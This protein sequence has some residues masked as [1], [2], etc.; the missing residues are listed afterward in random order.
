M[1]DTYTHGHHESVLR[2]HQWRTAENSAAYLLPSLRPGLDLL[3]VG[4]GPGT[5]TVD[6]AAR[7]APGNVVGVD[8]SADV[9]AQATALRHQ[10]GAANVTFSVVD[11][12]ALPF[13]DASFDV[14]H[15]H[16]VLQHVS[17]PVGM[18]REMHRVLRPGGLV[19]VR[20]SD[21]AAFMWA[22]A[23][24]M[25]DRWMQLYR[26][27][28]H[29]NGAQ[30][31]AGRHLLGWAHSAG[32]AD[33]VASSSTWT[34]ADLESR[35]WWGGLWADRMLLSSIAEQALAYGLSDSAELSAI[36]DAWRS[37]AAHPDGF[38]AVVHGEVLA[39]RASED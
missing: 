17:D 8:S 6:L 26:D 33:T 10:G 31:D 7:V 3:D 38:F 15:A 22:P 37:W 12:Y 11:A 19:A 29:R 32:F 14:V 28:A 36:S 13:D 25:M 30:P 27:V 4:C 18:L 24:P 21:F 20:D 35:A 16:Q 34:F 5:I 23:D 1:P 2:S 39:R 9:I